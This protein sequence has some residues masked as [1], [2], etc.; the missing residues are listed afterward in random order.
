M[1]SRLP[2]WRAV[3]CQQHFAPLGTTYPSL[4]K[5]NLTIYACINDS[6]FRAYHFDVDS[7]L[8]K[9]KCCMYVY[10]TTI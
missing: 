5:K 10:T 3:L 6:E 7:K 9:Y 2:T 8:F 4:L 1:I